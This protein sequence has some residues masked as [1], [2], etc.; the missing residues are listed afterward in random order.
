MKEKEVI[1]YILFILSPSCLAEQASGLSQRASPPDALGL[2]IRA[3]R[4]VA[5]SEK[6]GRCVRNSQKSPFFSENCYLPFFR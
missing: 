1:L 5:A 6:A 4:A 3:C 2:S